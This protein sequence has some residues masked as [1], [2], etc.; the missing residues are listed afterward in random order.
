[1]LGIEMKAMKVVILNKVL[2]ISPLK[3]KHLKK[4]KKYPG[5]MAHCIKHLLTKHEDWSSDCQN[6]SEI[7]LVNKGSDF[8]TSM[9]AFAI[10]CLSS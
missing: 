2:G 9:P 10:I 7:H 1:M 6:P 5:K 8:S 3:M 4:D